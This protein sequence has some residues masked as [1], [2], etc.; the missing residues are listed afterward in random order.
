[1]NEFPPGTLRSPNGELEATFAPRAG[2]VG[3]SLTHRG[4]ELLHIG[5]G[6]R[7]YVERGTTFGIP[8]LYPWANRLAGFDYTALGKHVRLEHGSPFMSLDPNGLP[9]HGLLGASTY[10]EVDQE[11][12][13]A[14]ALSASLDFGAYPALMQAFPYPHTVQLDILLLDTELHVATTVKPDRG[15][16]VPISFGF[17]PYLRLPGTPREE[18]EIEVPVREHLLVDRY[19]IPTGERE[20]AGDLNGPLGDRAFDDGYAG[21]EPDAPF[22][23]TGGGR[24]I[25]VRMNEGFPFAQV[26]SPPGAGFICFEPM[27][28]PTN[29]LRSGD[30]LPVAGPDKPFAAVWAIEVSATG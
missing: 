17:H 18:W 6:L 29:A 11:N 2:M 20:P 30:H 19:M 22:S 21:V 26:Y 8:L 4:K 10:W 25:E 28:A 23:I 1:V 7:E 13:E 24:R 16:A 12:I 15:V 14:G 27:T 9:I 5:S 3:C